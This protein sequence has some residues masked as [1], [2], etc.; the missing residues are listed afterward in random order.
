MQISFHGC[1][2]GDVFQMDGGVFWSKRFK[3]GVFRALRCA[4]FLFVVMASPSRSSELKEMI[5]YHSA[6][7]LIRGLISQLIALLSTVPSRARQSDG[8]R[9]LVDV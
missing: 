3:L 8:G 7:E 5:N 4:L 2:P 6:L 1:L 9:R